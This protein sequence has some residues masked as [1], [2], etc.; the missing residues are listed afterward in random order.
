MNANIKAV[1]KTAR[2]G[3]LHCFSRIRCKKP[4]NTISSP[5]GA[6]ITTAM[7]NKNP[8]KNDLGFNN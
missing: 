5:S 3:S 2:V 6:R 8:S 4:L 7:T 1:N